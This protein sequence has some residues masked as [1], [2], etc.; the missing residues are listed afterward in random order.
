MSGLGNFF[1][2]SSRRA[3]KATTTPRATS[4]SALEATGTSSIPILQLE[5]SRA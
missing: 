1:L 3:A 4:P 2:S 5:A